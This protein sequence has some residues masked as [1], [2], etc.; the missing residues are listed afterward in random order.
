MPA[1]LFPMDFLSGNANSAS[2]RRRSLPRFWRTLLPVLFVVSLLGAASGA[3]AEPV[4]KE[5]QLKAAFL[6]NFSKFVQWPQERFPD[7][8]SPI[9][10]AVLGPSPFGDELNKLVR[11]RLVNGRAIEVRPIVSAADI[12]A[13][14]IVFIPAGA[15]PLLEGRYLDARGV[16]T[17]GESAAFAAR[18]GMIRFTLVDEK[19]RFEIDQGSAEKAGLKLSGQLLKLATV[20]RKA[21]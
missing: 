9:I 15:E 17:V 20:I 8:G 10:I 4:S 11:E 18:G 5:Y 3:R 16:L 1:A 12:P 13:A 21:S 7:A 19:V 6:Y 2:R 14:H